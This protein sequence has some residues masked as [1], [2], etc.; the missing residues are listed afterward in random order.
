MF[1]TVKT[2]AFPDKV[3]TSPSKA[4]L[5]IYTTGATREFSSNCNHLPY[6]KM[7]ILISVVATGNYHIFECD[8]CYGLFLVATMVATGS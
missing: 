5:S 2:Q 1:L 4:K 3:L 6:L 7:T 8:V